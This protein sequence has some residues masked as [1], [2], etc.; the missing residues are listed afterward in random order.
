VAKN[1]SA[2]PRFVSYPTDLH[3]T[4]NSP[5]IDRGTSDGAPATDGAGSP[6]PVGAGFD[7]GVYEFSGQ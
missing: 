2:E 1:I 6:R 4:S 3:L 5:C 7:I